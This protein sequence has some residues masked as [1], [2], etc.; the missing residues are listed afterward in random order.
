MGARMSIPARNPSNG[1]VMSEDLAAQEF[2]ARHGGK[3]RFCRHNGSWFKWDG[4]IWRRNDSGIAFHFARELA[5]DLATNGDDRIRFIAGKSA[6]AA[7]VERFARCD[8]TFAIGSINDWDADPFKLGT[9]AGT[10]DLRTGSLRRSDPSDL[11]SKATLVAPSST[12]DCPRWK[13]FL[14][15]ATGGDAAFVRF[16]QQWCG[17]CL[18][19]SVK[20]HALVFIHGDGGRGKGTFVNTVSRI[21]GDYAVTAAM[22]T[23]IASKFDRNST[24]IAKLR[25]ARMVVAQE[26]EKGR[27]FAEAKLKNLTGGDRIAAR[28]LYQDEFEFDPQF[29]PV[30]VGN[31]R[32]TLQTVDDAISRRMNIAPFTRKP[33]TVDLDLKDKL[34][35]EAAGIL[36]WMIEGCLDWQANGLVR[37]PV[38]MTETA[39]YLAQ[40]DKLRQ[41]IDA[42]CE[43]ALDAW[44]PLAAL[45]A[46]WSEWA[47]E[48]GEKP[49]TLTDL[50]AGL[51]QKGFPRKKRNTGMGHLELRLLANGK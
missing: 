48:A 8:P 14:H 46:S 6:F 20:E 24:G 17:Y 2:A 31:H 23:F 29:K 5:R 51:E 12:S 35:G 28:F 44:S 7:G 10:V 47:K 15:E 38:V 25:G 43:Q 42:T 13:A 4:S 19:G 16:L 40:Q 18:T 11:I 36:R 30:I 34:L 39:N 27:P 37:P 21:L 41:W 45:F 32:P 26:T 1:A 33:A 49:G 3:L 9:P 50:S 22:E